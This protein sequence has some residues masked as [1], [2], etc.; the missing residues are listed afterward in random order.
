MPFYEY[1]CAEC[2]HEFEVMQKMNDASLRN[3]P[4]CGKPELDKLISVAG[5]QLKGGSCSRPTDDVPA[6]G[7]GGACP[8]CE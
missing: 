6:C 3:C 4:E 2:G 7:A 5:F 1:R 8:A